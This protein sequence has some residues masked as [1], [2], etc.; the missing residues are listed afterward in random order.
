[1]LDRIHPEAVDV[2]VGDPEFVCLAQ[3]PESRRGDVVIDV[4]VP[5]VDIFQV[6]KVTF[7]IFRVVIPA[8]DP[9]FTGE[10]SAC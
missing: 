4:T 2:G 5:Q 3:S 1:V 7:Q 6:E 9:S 8:V 10:D